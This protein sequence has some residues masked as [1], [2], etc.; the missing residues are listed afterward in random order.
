MNNLKKLKEK[1]SKFFDKIQ[2]NY[3]S[4][5]HSPRSVEHKEKAKQ[6]TEEFIKE[7]ARKEGKVVKED[8]VVTGEKLSESIDDKNFREKSYYSNNLPSLI[9]REK[10]ERANKES[11]KGLERDKKD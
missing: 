7:A 8:I 2:S 1:I 11:R 4:T 10:N 5:Y 6:D 3:R 9:G